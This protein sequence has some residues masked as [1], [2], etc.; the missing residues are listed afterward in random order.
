MY[1]VVDLVG[2]FTLWIDQACFL[3]SNQN[4]KCKTNNE[5]IKS[6]LHKRNAKFVQ[7]LRRE[8]EQ[9][10]ANCHMLHVASSSQH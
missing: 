3:S 4:S 9:G 6:N 10:L 5:S 1:L 2:C 8:N 7:K